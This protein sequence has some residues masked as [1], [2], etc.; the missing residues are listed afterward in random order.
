MF[1]CSQE[2]VCLFITLIQ[3]TYVN[4][5]SATTDIVNKCQGKVEKMINYPC[6]CVVHQGDAVLVPLLPLASCLSSS[7]VEVQDE[8]PH[9]LFTVLGMLQ[10]S[11]Y[12]HGGRVG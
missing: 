11:K 6:I 4:E 9:F 7:E 10:L 3:M 2:R 8:E 5:A 1:G 12:L